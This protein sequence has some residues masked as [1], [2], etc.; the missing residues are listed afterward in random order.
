M[1]IDNTPGCQRHVK[2]RINSI[3]YISSLRQH[4]IVAVRKYFLESTYLNIWYRLVK[5]F[6]INVADIICGNKPGNDSGRI[7]TNTTKTTVLVD[8]CGFHNED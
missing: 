1:G 2:S 8:H 7:R 5:P 6:S 3:Y 4:S